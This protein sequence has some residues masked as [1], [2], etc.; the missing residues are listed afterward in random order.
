VETLEQLKL[1]EYTRA[2][3]QPSALVDQALSWLDGHALQAARL[4]RAETKSVIWLDPI[5]LKSKS[6]FAST[7]FFEDLGTTYLT[8]LA[9]RYVPPQTFF[10]K[11]SIYPL[12]ENLFHEATHQEIYSLMDQGKL[13]DLPLRGNDGPTIEVLSRALAPFRGQMSSLAMTLIDEASGFV[14]PDLGS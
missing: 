1:T 2:D 14:N 7:T 5:D 11:N 8:P 4:I 12:A 6:V 9:Q 10:S 3:Q 13:L